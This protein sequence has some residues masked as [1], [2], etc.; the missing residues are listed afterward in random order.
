LLKLDCEGSEYII[1][2]SLPDS[3]FEHIKKIVMEYH[4]ADKKPNL[5]Q[6]LIKKLN[7]L[8]YKIDVRKNT[9]DSGII[10]AIKE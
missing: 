8:N 2:N 4:M 6:N 5:L 1:L 9:D 7:V 3:Y 10:F